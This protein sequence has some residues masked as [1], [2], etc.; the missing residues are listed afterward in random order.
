MYI[1]IFQR[2]STILWLLSS[3][4]LYQ[5]LQYIGL[6]STHSAVLNLVSEICE[7]FDKEVW[8]WKS[9]I[10]LQETKHDLQM[11]VIK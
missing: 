5:R 8:E 11:P 6:S 3:F 7:T 2:H 4:Q 9:E 10:E 1:Y